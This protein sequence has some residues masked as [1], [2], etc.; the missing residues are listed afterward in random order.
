MILDNIDRLD[1]VFF[2]LFHAEDGVDH[3]FGIEVLFRADDFAAHG[4]FDTVNETVPAQVIDF[5]AQ[6]VLDVAASL[7]TGDLVAA[8]DAGGMQLVVDQLM[9]FFNKFR[10]KDDHG[11]G[12][13][14]DFF[15]L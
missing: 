3:H 4:G 12:A 9:C 6:I 1:R 5:E 10:S 15:V 8:H 14:S 11:S 7:A 13:V 2:P